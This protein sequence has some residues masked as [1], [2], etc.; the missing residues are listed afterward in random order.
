[1]SVLTTIILYLQT[2]ADHIV[3]SVGQT[4]EA[5]KEALQYVCSHYSLS[6]HC[7]I[8]Y[9]GHYDKVQISFKSKLH[10]H[11]MPAAMSV[12]RDWR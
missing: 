6:S 11:G 10:Y 7:N 3:Q 5:E 9:S 12:L 1:M 4:K 2:T 8:K